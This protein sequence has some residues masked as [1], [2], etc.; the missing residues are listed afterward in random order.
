M[1]QTNAIRAELER[2]L[3]RI[4][5]VDRHPGRIGRGSTFSVRATEIAHFHGDQRLDVRLTKE[6]IRQHL[7]EAPFDGR[8]R[9]RGPSAEWVAVQVCRPEDIP[10]AV[11][12]VTEARDANGSS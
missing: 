12:L 3:S 2:E 5:G 9:T 8:V 11:A 6:R 4:A 10:I 7:A 1:A